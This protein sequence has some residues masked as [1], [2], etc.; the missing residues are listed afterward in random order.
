MNKDNIKTYFNCL[1]DDLEKNYVN[2]LLDFDE[3]SIHKFRVC[4]KKINA[5]SQLPLFNKHS[6]FRFNKNIKHIYN[7]LGHL[8]DQQ[9][10]YTK[11]IDN[12]KYPPFNLYWFIHQLNR[13][14]TKIKYLILLKKN[15][16]LCNKSSDELLVNIKTNI[17]KKKINKHIQ[18][19]IDKLNTVI[20]LNKFDDHILHDL[21]K[22]LKNLYYYFTLKCT[23]EFNISSTLKYK[24]DDLAAISSKLGEIQDYFFQID[25]LNPRKL[26]KIPLEEIKLLQPIREEWINK[27]NMLKITLILELK[28]L[29]TK[30]I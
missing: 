30:V 27:K 12:L 14:N 4:Y 28:M 11:L 1:I 9:I 17:S 16:G 18:L 22:K 2:L 19:S 3:E 24:V 5:L 10:L 15:K 26:S 29:L 20:M 25:E 23:N 21:R 8:R 6:K 13:K 7:L